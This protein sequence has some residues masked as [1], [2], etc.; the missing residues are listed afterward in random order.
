MSAIGVASGQGY[1]A[2]C[3]PCWP[4]YESETGFA[5]GLIT[6]LGTGAWHQLDLSTVPAGCD[7]IPNRYLTGIAVDPVGSAGTRSSPSRATRAT[8]WSGRTTPGSA[9]SS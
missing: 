2:W 8:G 4:G 1:A 5:R 3:G 7:A 6:N 9:M